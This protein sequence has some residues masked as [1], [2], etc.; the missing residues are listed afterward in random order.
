MKAIYLVE[1]YFELAA[2]RHLMTRQR[3]LARCNY[4]ALRILVQEAE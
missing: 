1:I 4:L 3:Y 2:D